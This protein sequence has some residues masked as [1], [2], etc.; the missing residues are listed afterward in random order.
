MSPAPSSM[1]AESLARDNKKAMTIPG[2]TAC[3]IASPTIATAQKGESI[4]KRML[5]VIGD[6]V[7][8]RPGGKQVFELTLA[9]NPIVLQSQDGWHAVSIDGSDDYLR[10]V[11]KSV[12][13][14][15]ES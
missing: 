10:W 7:F 13:K 14:P 4:Y 15:R 12:G 6:K 1:V 3:E 5:H 8:D 9:Y 2:N 11:E